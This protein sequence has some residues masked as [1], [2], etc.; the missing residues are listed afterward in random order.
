MLIVSRVEQLVK[1][2]QRAKSIR[3]EWAQ[4]EADGKD[5]S[6]KMGILRTYY[7][8]SEQYFKHR[9]W[10]QSNLPKITSK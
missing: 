3:E 7:L 4:A 10:F 2:K 9:Y 8:V 6:F 1:I 5:D